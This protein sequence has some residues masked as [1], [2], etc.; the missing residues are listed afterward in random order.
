MTGAQP[1]CSGHQG[2]IFLGETFKQS[3]IAD[4]PL[5]TTLD[6][7]QEETAPLKF[8]LMPAPG[9]LTGCH[10]RYQL[11]FWCTIDEASPP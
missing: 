10:H 1:L 8:T 4:L 9:T 6:L 11:A 5:H 3:N 7:S 2:L